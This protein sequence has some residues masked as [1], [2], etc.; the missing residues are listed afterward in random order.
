MVGKRQRTGYQIKGAQKRVDALVTKMQGWNG[1]AYP[2]GL[3]NWK[4]SAEEVSKAK[5]NKEQWI[6]YT[7]RTRLLWLSFCERQGR[8]RGPSELDFKSHFEKAENRVSIYIDRIFPALH[9]CIQKELPYLP[10]MKAGKVDK[11]SMDQTQV[12][13]PPLISGRYGNSF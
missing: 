1:P 10:G 5:T 3:E 2:A 7:L 6:L 9:F 4:L 11:V 12:A 8:G 13:P